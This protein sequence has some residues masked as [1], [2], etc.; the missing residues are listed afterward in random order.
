MKP[1]KKAAFVHNH[2]FDGDVRRDWYG[3]GRKLFAVTHDGELL[4]G[5]GWVMALIDD[6][7]NVTKVFDKDA[8]RAAEA[9][10]GCKA[11]WAGTAADIDRMKRWLPD[12]PIPSLH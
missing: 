8:I 4:D 7:C 1:V 5:E 3:L 12:S 11:E 6:D 9:I 10:R 2:D